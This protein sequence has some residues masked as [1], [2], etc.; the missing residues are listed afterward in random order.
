MPTKKL[1]D[2]EARSY[3]GEGMTPKSEGVPSL[4]NLYTTEAE[5]S[6]KQSEAE[7]LIADPDISDEDFAK[8]RKGTN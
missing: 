7:K 1:T 6:Q 5:A 3:A 8:L 2:A 4:L